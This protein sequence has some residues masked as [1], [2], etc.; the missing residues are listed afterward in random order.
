MTQTELAE[1]LG[2]AQSQVSRYCA[3]GMPM[4][5]PGAKAWI[6]RHIRLTMKAPLYRRQ[7]RPMQ[8]QAAAPAL[9]VAELVTLAEDIG[10]IMCDDG[11]R[12]GVFDE[13]M[14]HLMNTLGL[15]ARLDEAAVARVR[16]P[17]RCC[18]AVCA[19][20]DSTAGD[21]ATA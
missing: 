12:P 6:S 9:S 16:L 15:L 2:I 5:A 14:P 8:R 10:Q 19:W 20:L 21:E 3:R 18:D 4:D 7:T 17:Q 11:D 13:G 1:A